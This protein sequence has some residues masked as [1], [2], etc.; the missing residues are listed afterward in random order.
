MGKMS[1]RP[2]SEAIKLL[3][4]I[5]PSEEAYEKEGHLYSPWLSFKINAQ[6]NLHEKEACQG[7]VIDT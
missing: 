2:K 1:N 4:E 5:N 7:T 3:N 6:G